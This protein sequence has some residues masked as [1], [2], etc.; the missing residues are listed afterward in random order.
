MTINLSKLK[1]LEKARR[2]PCTRKLASTLKMTSEDM[3]FTIA[4]REVGLELLER[5]EKLEDVAAAARPYISDKVEICS[6]ETVRRHA[7]KAQD[8]DAA[9]YALDSTARKEDQ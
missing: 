3:Q 4:L 6:E 1:D 8:L 2:Y 7:K 9:F 5:M